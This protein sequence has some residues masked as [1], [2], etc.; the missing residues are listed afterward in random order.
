MAG[1]S[2]CRWP[3]GRSAGDPARRAGARARWARDDRPGWHLNG[4]CGPAGGEIGAGQ[5][6]AHRERR[7]GRAG[8]RNHARGEAEAPR[9]AVDERVESPTQATGAGNRPGRGGD[10]QVPRASRRP[11]SQSRH[12]LVRERHGREHVCDRAG[13]KNPALSGAEPRR[14]GPRPTAPLRQMG[15]RGVRRRTWR[16][17]APQAVTSTWWPRCCRGARR[18]GSAAQ[19]DRRRLRPRVRLLPL[20][21][22]DRTLTA[23]LT[24]TGSGQPGR[25]AATRPARANLR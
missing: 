15:S 8:Y 7:G 11:S 17:E 13:G 2:S 1:K 6:G 14:G 10:A 23:L 9:C 19:R 21:R 3:R 20:G 25:R 22:R 4:G 5:A 16:R 18:R 12:S 24:A